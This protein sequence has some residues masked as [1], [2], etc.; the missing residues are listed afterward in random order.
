MLYLIGLGLGLKGISVE[1]LKIVNLCKKVYLENYTVDF[2]YSENILK[3]FIEKKVEIIDRKKVESLEIIDEAKKKDVALLVY[4]SPLT[5]TTHIS[6]I[7]EAKHSRVKC[8]VIYAGSIL[9]AVG[10]TGLQ[11]YKF[12][13][14]TSMPAWKKNFTPTSFVETIQENQ[15]ISAH[16][17]ILIDIGLPFEKAIEQFKKSLEEHKMNIKKFLVCSNLGTKNKKIYFKT[18]KEFEEYKIRKPFCFI[19]PG[20]LHFAE[21]EFLKRFEE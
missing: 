16:S 3:E 1:G 11:I 19:I 6:L 8:R 15:K 21:E 18:L 13:K 14:I 17:L 9:D 10:E 4:G 5:A 7:D 2:P 20:K 12:G